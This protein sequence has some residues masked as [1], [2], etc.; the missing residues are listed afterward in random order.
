[1]IESFEMIHMFI[2]RGRG[3]RYD[4]RG[5][6]GHHTLDPTGSIEWAK[7]YISAMIWLRLGSLQGLLNP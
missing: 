7:D 4:R 2:D 6:D 1:M 3:Q 5:F